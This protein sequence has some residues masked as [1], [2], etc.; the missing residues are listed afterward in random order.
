[1]NTE[2]RLKQI[3]LEESK[4]ASKNPHMSLKEA[5][6]IV[7]NLAEAKWIHNFWKKL[8]T[9]QLQAIRKIS[10]YIEHGKFPFDES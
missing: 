9:R 4:I 5:M 1:M 7:L 10:P 3:H 6:I 2:C 8:T